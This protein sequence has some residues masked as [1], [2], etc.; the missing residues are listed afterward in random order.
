[1]K[2]AIMILCLALASFSTIASTYK[3]NV[4]GGDDY[5]VEINL[6]SKKAALW[7]NNEWS[8]IRQS[9]QQSPLSAL[10]VFT[11]KDSFGDAVAIS[12]DT[13]E[14]ANLTGKYGEVKFMTGR[15]HV[16]KVLRDCSYA[17]SLNSGI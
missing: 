15:G 17:R 11:G 3:C 13:S 4:P 9:A 7:D 6:K 8:V 14:T 5:K 12:F 2:N 16:K 1:M 10:I